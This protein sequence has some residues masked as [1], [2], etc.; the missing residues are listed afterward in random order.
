MVK[1]GESPSYVKQRI[2]GILHQEGLDG[3]RVYCYPIADRGAVY[4]PK[5]REMVFGFEAE[6]MCLVLHEVAH[7]RYFRHTEAWADYYLNLLRKYW[8]R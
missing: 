3:V 6:D 1:S 2:L 4:C 7:V 5:T 8:R